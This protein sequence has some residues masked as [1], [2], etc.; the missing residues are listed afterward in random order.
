VKRVIK[1]GGRPQQDPALPGLVAEAWDSLGHAL[2]IVHGGGDEVT[3]LQTA[4]GGTAQFIDGRRVTT[5][6]DIEI[7]RMALSGSA[8]KRLV[9]NLVH[10]GVRAVGLSG[11]DGSLIAATPTDVAQLGQVG[12]PQRINVSLLWHLLDG[13][14]LP[15]ISPVSRDVS[16]K[17]RANASC[18]GCGALNVNG[19]DAAGAIAVAMDADELLLVV[20]VPGVMV[21]DKPLA[22]LGAEHACELIANRTATAGMAAKLQAALAALEAGVARV[23][24]GDVTAIRELDNG[25]TLVRG[26]GPS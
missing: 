7:V 11:E 20:D 8:N 2:V 12:T 9:S 26:G 3:A 24:I 19:D 14:Y 10:E 23:R 1:V 5:A 25:T 15:V 16:S 18:L 4:L 22:R 6:Q 21:D 13:G 17:P